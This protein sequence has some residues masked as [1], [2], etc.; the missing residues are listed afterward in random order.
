VRRDGRELCVVILRRWPLPQVLPPLLPPLLLLGWLAVRALHCIDDGDGTCAKVVSGAVPPAPRRY[1]CASGHSCRRLNAW[2]YQCTPDEAPG[3]SSGAL[4]LWDQC[5]GKDGTT[6]GKA[7]P[8]GA[9]VGWRRVGPRPEC[10][11][12]L[13]QRTRW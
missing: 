2:Y 9:L 4:A 10:L 3:P 8:A 1:Q 13:S 7:C 12:L 5:G 11:V 6:P